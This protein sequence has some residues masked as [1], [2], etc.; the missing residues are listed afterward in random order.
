MHSSTVIS[1]GPDMC[2]RSATT[3]FSAYLSAA[4]GTAT[5]NVYGKVAKNAPWKLLGTT[6]PLS[7]ANDHDEFTVVGEAW[8]FVKGDIS[9]IGGGALATVAMGS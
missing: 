5:C 9:A 1:S 8:P 4:G 3:L 2:P 6:R 7:G